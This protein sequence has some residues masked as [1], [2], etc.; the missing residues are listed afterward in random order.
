MNSEFLSPRQVII[1]RLKSSA[2]PNM[3]LLLEGI[4]KLSK[5]E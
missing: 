2:Y 4:L 3:K 1:P 5:K